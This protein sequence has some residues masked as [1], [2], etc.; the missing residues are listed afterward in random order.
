[1]LDKKILFFTPMLNSNGLFLLWNR[2]IA[3]LQTGICCYF[4]RIHMH[5]INSLFTVPQRDKV[6]Q[7]FNSNVRFEC[8]RWMLN[9][10][11]VGWNVKE[12]NC[13]LNVCRPWVIKFFFSFWVTT[14]KDNKKSRTNNAIRCVQMHRQFDIHLIERTNKTEIWAV[15]MSLSWKLTGN[16]DEKHWPK[17]P[18]IK[19]LTLSM[20]SATHSFSYTQNDRLALLNWNDAQA[21]T[22]IS[23]RP[24]HTVRIEIDSERRW[25]LL[26]PLTQSLY[27]DATDECVFCWYFGFTSECLCL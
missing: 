19:K 12:V 6:E 25:L 5:E 26:A 13:V 15:R 24:A 16:Y 3:S 22:Q 17:G 27:L 4:S 20:F 2:P 9:A 1:M 10:W 18:T 7:S 23:D 8:D 11:F 14:H 21:W